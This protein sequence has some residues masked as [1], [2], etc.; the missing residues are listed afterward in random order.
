MCITDIPNIEARVL[1]WG[2]DLKVVAEGFPFAAESTAKRLFISVFTYIP[3]KFCNI[4][5]HL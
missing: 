4:C 5:L 1:S 2:M 3:A